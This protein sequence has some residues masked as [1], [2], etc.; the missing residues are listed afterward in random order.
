[1]TEVSFS[2]VLIFLPGVRGG[3]VGG[4]G[5]CVCVLGSGEEGHLA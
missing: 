4:E 3:G 5:V 2:A 1:M